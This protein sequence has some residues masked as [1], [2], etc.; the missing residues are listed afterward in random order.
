MRSLRR[1]LINF[2]ASLLFFIVLAE[3]GSYAALWA[4]GESSKTFSEIYD[5][6][7]NTA[8]FKGKCEDYIK[9]L[10]LNPYLG[11]TQNK[12]CSGLGYRVNNLGLLNQDVDFMKA[13]HYAVGIFGGSVAAQFAGYTDV[14][15]IERI[16]NKCFSSPS[17]KPFIVYNFSGGAW[18][19]PQQ[20][21]ALTLYGD[22]IN[23]AI[24]I[25]GFNE[26]WA[27]MPGVNFDM[28]VPASNYSSLLN[29]DYLTDFYFNLDKLNGGCFS[30]SNTIKLFTLLFRKNLQKRSLDNYY[31]KLVEKYA[32]PPSVNSLDLNAK[33]YAGFI[34]SF[35]AI[36]S[37]KNVYS[38]FVLQPA[39]LNKQLTSAE[40]RAVTPLNYR[41]QYSE[42]AYLLKNNARAF[43]DLSDLFN[44][45]DSDVFK[46]E[47][48]FV[49][50]GSDYKSY[51][52]F[53]MATDIARKLLSDKVVVEKEGPEDC[54]ASED[55]Q[56]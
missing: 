45:T 1:S 14:P 13:T 20:E 39:P 23:I 27:F 56:N 52:N 12:K 24:S 15:Q 53:K 7:R 26:H 2:A 37:S 8:R 32:F 25:E 47:I 3:V 51:G 50:D 35:D 33:R 43:I 38:L 31:S 40:I 6:T 5:P 9:T 28:I 46:D 49:T 11:F 22:Y 48:H 10:E 54:M 16:L 4:L 42:I 55:P 36:A 34:R 41:Q 17:G 21:I 44:K 30:K 29:G 19:H 18:K